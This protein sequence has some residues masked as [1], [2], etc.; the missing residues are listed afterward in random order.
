M[1]WVYIIV[2]FLVL[3]VLIYVRFKH[4]E[5]DPFGNLHLPKEQKN[6]KEAENDIN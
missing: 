1:V 2:L 4:K 6:S 5:V 3:L